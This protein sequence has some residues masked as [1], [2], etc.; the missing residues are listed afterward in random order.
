M[1]KQNGF[2]AD[3][4]N[5]L[6]ER[7]IADE[8][9]SRKSDKNEKLCDLHSE[10]KVS[11]SSRIQDDTSDISE[12]DGHSDS[13]G[14]K[15]TKLE[16]DKE[17]INGA[18]PSQ[19]YIA[20]IAMA[21][22]SSPERKMVLADI[23]NYILE[24]YPFYKT[25][26]KSWRNSI[27]HNLSLNECFIKAGR[28]ENGKGNYWAIHPSNV[29]DFAKGDYRR[30]RARRKTKRP[31][32]TF[33]LYSELFHPY[34]TLSPMNRIGKKIMMPMFMG[35]C[36]RRY[37]GEQKI[38]KVFPQQ[39]Q[40][41]SFTIDSIL[42]LEKEKKTDNNIVD[43]PESRVRRHYS[44]PT[45]IY[46]RNPTYAESAFSPVHRHTNAGHYQVSYQDHYYKRS[47]YLPYGLL[48]MRDS[49]QELNRL[50]KSVS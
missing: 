7:K 4:N 49:I 18:K 17:E 45:Y 32:H 46:P 44:T 37:E 11:N 50:R 20:L 5:N 12:C 15:K 48:H 8:Y 19:S 42:G 29:E 38:N 36:E 31:V 3:N 9:F 23:Y 35:G 26:D 27:R 6:K 33:G 28:S 47:E 43:L 24:N 40:R 13:M 1:E 34:T 41:K 22:L 39:K 25:Q 10:C 14:A 21:I 30:R 16:G 2:E